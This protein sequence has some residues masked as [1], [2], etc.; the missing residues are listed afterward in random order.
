MKAPDARDP[1]ATQP[2][3]PQRVGFFTILSYMLLVFS[4]PRFVS[5]VAVRWAARQ[6]TCWMAW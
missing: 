4:V 1:A 6:P 2:S 5:N 3:R